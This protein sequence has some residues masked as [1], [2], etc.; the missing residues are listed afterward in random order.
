MAAKKQEITKHKASLSRGVAPTSDPSQVFD[1]V[2]RGRVRADATSRPVIAGNKPQVADNTLATAPTLG[3]KLRGELKIT[4]PSMSSSTKT[5]EPEANEQA[6]PKEKGVSVTDLLAKKTEEQNA[7]SGDAV[8][9]GSTIDLTP[10]SAAPE[11]TPPTALDRLLMDDDEKD[12]ASTPTETD[13]KTDDK[14][15]FKSIE[16]NIDNDEAL[17]KALQ[18][19]DATKPQE[20]SEALKEEMK[21]IG[22]DGRPHYDLYGGKPVIVVHKD[23]GTSSA[24]MLVIWFFVC[25]LLALAIVDVLLDAGIIK[26]SYD[27]PFTNFIKE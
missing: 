26:T 9:V 13:E 14:P 15:E 22:E 3:L 5:N 8:D 1:I 25:V 11:A 2:P 4:P 20:H 7:V 17:A 10:K 19:D 23:H 21:N 24:L 6:T 18:Q 12:V 16:G 27:I